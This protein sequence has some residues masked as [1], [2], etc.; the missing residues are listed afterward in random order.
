MSAQAVYK[1]AYAPRRGVYAILYTGPADTYSPAAVAAAVEVAVA[2]L[3]PPWRS[4]SCL[5]M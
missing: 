4:R 3:R 2:R 5:Q 1:N